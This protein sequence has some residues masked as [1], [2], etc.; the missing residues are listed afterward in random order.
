MDSAT[1][2]AIQ[3]DIVRLREENPGVEF[4][5]VVSPSF[6]LRFERDLSTSRFLGCDLFYDL[7]QKE[8]W[9]FKQVHKS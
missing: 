2:T 3:A 4:N 1:K 6:F 5:M 8:D 7:D 9:V